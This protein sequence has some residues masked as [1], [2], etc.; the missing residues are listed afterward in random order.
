MPNPR[1]NWWESGAGGGN[2]YGTRPVI[3]LPTQTQGGALGGNLANLGQIYGLTGGVNSAGA[4]NAAGNLT[5]NVPGLAERSRGQLPMDV[6]TQLLQQAAERGIST[7]APGG[8]NANA[9][10]LRAL[11]LTSLGVA[12]DAGKEIEAGI[13]SAPKVDPNRLLISPEDQQ[14]AEVMRAIYASAPDPASAAAASRANAQAGIGAGLGTGNAGPWWSQA[15][16]NVAS[17]TPFGMP[18]HW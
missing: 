12:T 14:Q 4:A 10:Y 16:S 5:A 7:G 3:P 18:S 6:I 13:L 1:A 2:A 15:Y 17:Y 8:P 11:G 9:A